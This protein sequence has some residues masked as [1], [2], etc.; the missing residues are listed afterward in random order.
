MDQPEYHDP[1]QRIV[2]PDNH[3]HIETPLAFA[4]LLSARLGY[5]IYLKLENLQPSQ[6]FK[7][8]GISLFAVRAVKE[9]GP[10]VHL[11][12]ASSGNAG[13]ALAW[14]G[15][16]LGVR[17]S[18]YIP[19]S[20]SS[21]QGALSIAGAEV[22]IGGND[23]TDALVSA[24]QFCNNNAH[25]VLA[26]SYDHETLW[27]GHATMIHEAAHQLPSGVV[28]DA[29][30]CSVGGGGLLGGVIRGMNDV[31]WDQTQ[32]ITFETHGSNCFHLSLLA[33]SDEPVARSLIPEDTVLSEVPPLTG[34]QQEFPKEHVTIAKLPGI[35]SEAISL[36]ARSP[37]QITV[38]ASLTRRAR[39][40]R[41]PSGLGG[42]T[43]V[44]IPDVI[45]MRAALGFLD[46]QKL[47]V[48]LACAA[49]L[50]PAYIP[51][52][53]AALIPT[54]PSR[55]L[56]VVFIVCGG[57]KTTYEDAARY[58]CMIT[59]RDLAAASQDIVINSRMGLP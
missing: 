30:L 19:T 25:A 13:L 2:D 49:T 16:S 29:V 45:A 12:A 7:Y 57:S 36:G 52:F 31:G 17:I 8:R 47:L 48:E 40:A 26:P 38:E 53:L 34:L 37:A 14:V 3:M 10:S 22:V 55:R 51:G 58:H 42:L 9:H 20:A 56:V 15:K 27:E 1:Q 32:I 4:P 50:A 44:T 35:T 23:Y 41:D 24:Q 6:S 33:N 11:V 43:A 28:P 54:T 59:D 18:I 39:A 21:V 5:D 46:E